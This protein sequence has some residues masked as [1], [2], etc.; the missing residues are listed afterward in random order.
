[1]III[2]DDTC[3]SEVWLVPRKTG[4]YIPATFRDPKAEVVRA[5]N[6]ATWGAPRGKSLKVYPS[7]LSSVEVVNNVCRIR[8]A[9]EGK[10]SILESILKWSGCQRSVTLHSECRLQPA[11]LPVHEELV[12]VY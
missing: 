8:F 4:G 11:V 12:K 10:N 7:D 9:A 2:I 3:F 1:M 5:L 6:Q